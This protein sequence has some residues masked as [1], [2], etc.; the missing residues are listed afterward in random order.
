[1]L[2][3]TLLKP[4]LVLPGEA[5]CRKGESGDS[6]YF[7]SSGAIA[8]QIDPEPVILGTGDFFG[9][10][11][12]LNDVPRSSDVMAETYS[13]LLVLERRDFQKLLDNNPDLRDTIEKVAEERLKS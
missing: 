1:M 4:Q 9:E 2:I 8:V 3:T 11:A 10:I 12:L 5:I 6:M 7:V 13:D